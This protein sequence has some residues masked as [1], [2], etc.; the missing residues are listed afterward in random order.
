MNNPYESPS[1]DVSTTTRT[2]I[3]DIDISFGRLIV[4]MLKTMLASIPAVIVMYAI[5]FAIVLVIALLFGGFGALMGGLNPEA[6]GK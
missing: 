3:T 4:I 6:L 2:V 1:A 5:M